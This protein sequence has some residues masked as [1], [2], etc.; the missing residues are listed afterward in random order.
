VP[1]VT[2]HGYCTAI[3]SITFRSPA[4]VDWSKGNQVQPLV[5]RAQDESVE[6]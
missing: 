6:F 5:K 2:G 3:A 1:A 4:A